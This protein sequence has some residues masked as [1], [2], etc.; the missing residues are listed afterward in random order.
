MTPMPVRATLRDLGQALAEEGSGPMRDDDRP[1]GFWLKEVDRLL[2]EGFDRALAGQG[3]AR[4]HWQAMNVLQSQPQSQP[5]TLEALGAALRPF[6]HPGTI[7]LA[8]VVDELGRAGWITAGDPVALTPA[9]EAAHAA[10]SGRVRAV[11]EQLVQGL[12]RE[13]YLATVDC[14]RR[15]AANLAPPAG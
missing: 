11:R 2:E 6:W 7:T 13:E 12:R 9:G 8:E 1:I 4:R 15:M 5:L 3:L 14:L 10:A